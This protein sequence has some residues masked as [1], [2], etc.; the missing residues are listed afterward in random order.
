MLIR[1][2]HPDEHGLY[3]EHLK[4][5]S[6]D[7]RRSRFSETVVSDDVIEA[8]V[9]KISP[10]DMV[11]GAFDK[12]DRL[13]AAAHV[14]LGGAIAEIGVSVEP[15]HR[16]K[17][18]GTELTDHAAKWARNRHAHKLYSVY[19]DSNRSM[20]GVAHHMDMSVTHDHGVAEAI[21][22]LAPPDAATVSDEL[23]ADFQEMWRD[24]SKRSSGFRIYGKEKL[25]CTCPM[26]FRKRSVG[27]VL[28][29]VASSFSVLKLLS[30]RCFNA[31]AIGAKALENQ[32]AGCSSAW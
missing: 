2:L 10:E 24:W 8:Y 25:L 16:G 3:L 7:D 29:R 21:L 27:T 6:P 9:D 13:V 18:L 1:K 20:Q 11:L 15:D 4:R 5:L 26:I 23:V 12:T 22:N 31:C 17:H 28:K 32:G 30:R 14:G 19:S